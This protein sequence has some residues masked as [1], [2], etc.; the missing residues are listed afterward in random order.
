MGII[1][2][3]LYNMDI[4]LVCYVINLIMVSADTVIYFRNK[5][6]EAQGDGSGTRED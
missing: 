1:H 2:K 3:I 4:V 6:L 5:R